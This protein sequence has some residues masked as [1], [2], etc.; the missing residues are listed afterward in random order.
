[1][2]LYRVTAEKSSDYGIHPITEYVAAPSFEALTALYEKNI[3]LNIERVT[4]RVRVIQ[5]DP[6][7]H[8]G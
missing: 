1:M 7:D 2:I 4:E 5:R 3:V 8:L 6:S